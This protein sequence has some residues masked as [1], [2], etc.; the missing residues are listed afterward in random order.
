MSA[1][2][3]DLGNVEYLYLRNVD[4]NNGNGGQIAE[5]FTW[6]MPYI[7]PKEAPYMFIQVVQLYVD[8][9]LGNGAAEPHHLRFTSVNGLNN[10]STGSSQLATLMERDAPGG[11]WLN[12]PEAPMIQVPS[13][14]NQLSFSLNR[15]FN[16][17]LIEIGENGCIDMVLKIV[18]PKQQEITNNTLASYVRTMP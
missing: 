1:T 15:N 8:H 17:D 14:I 5:S 7:T 3:V 12:K 18:R 9:K 4:C 11:H 10:Y 6:T 13:N 2:N 16:G